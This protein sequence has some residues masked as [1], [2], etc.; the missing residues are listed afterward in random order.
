MAKGIA[1][2]RAKT[3]AWNVALRVA[4]AGPA[5]YVLTSILTACIA[6]LLPM[7]PAEASIAATLFSFAIF[8]G[9]A[10]VAFAVR[11]VTT[12]WLWI[13]VSGTVAA[14]VLWLSLMVGGR[15]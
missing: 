7:P 4:A 15:L 1:P 13:L 6:R 3:T 14:S 2:P 5:N 9:I 12:L 10:L 8:A 11:S